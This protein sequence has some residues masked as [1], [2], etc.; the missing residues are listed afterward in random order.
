MDDRPR[1]PID[2]RAWKSAL[3][4][5]LE[6][7][8]LRDR[9]GLAL[10]V[11]GWIHLGFFLVNQAFY[12]PDSSRATLSLALWAAELFAA[13]ATIRLVAGPGWHRSSPLGGLIVRVWGTFLLVSFNVVSLNTLTGWTLDWFKPVWA[14]LSIFGFMMMAYLV[15]FKFFYLAAL[16]Y[17]TGLIM[18]R[19]PGLNYLIYGLSWWAALQAIGLSLERRRRRATAPR[20][21]WPREAVLEPE[22]A[23]HAGA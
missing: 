4:V 12:T 19:Y 18:V 8:A 20:R 17:F 13:L 1:Y 3:V 22:P 14:T 5:D 23:G 15:S 10:M 11:V 21:P 2:L 6:R 7:V 9:W 16:M